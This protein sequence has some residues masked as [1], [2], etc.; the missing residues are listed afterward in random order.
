MR[1]KIQTVFVLITPLLIFTCYTQREAL[2]LHGD[3][4]V[5]GSSGFVSPEVVWEKNYGSGFYEDDAFSITP[6]SEGGYLLAGIRYGGENDPRRERVY[7]TKIDDGGDAVWDSTFW[8]YLEPS[9]VLSACE[10]ENGNLLLTGW[11]VEGNYY[12]PHIWEFDRDLNKIRDGS[13]GKGGYYSFGRITQTDDGGFIAAGATTAG[14]SGVNTFIARF[15]DK[16]RLAWSKHSE[17]KMNDG[18]ADIIENS[19]GSFTSAGCTNSWAKGKKDAYIVNVDKDGTII[20]SNSFGGYDDDE[21]LA[22]CPAADGGFFLA[23]YSKSFADDGED[24]YIVKTDNEGNLVWE[25]I[26]GGN[27]DDRAY[28]LQPTE[29]GCLVAGYS[30]AGIFRET[31]FYVMEIDHNG[32]VIWENK[33]G[34]KDVGKARS[35]AKNDDGTYVIAGSTKPFYAKSDVFAVKIKLR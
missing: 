2:V 1:K 26:Y 24:I 35:I 15:D 16:N 33:F 25:N 14:G 22:I 17:G 18:L 19:D 34:Y 28:A 13:I 30:E 32:S 5:I 9:G 10:K 11:T 7:L 8:Y 29:R 6:L 31:D 20:W 3:A 4:Y 21:A 12:R 23:G 27:K